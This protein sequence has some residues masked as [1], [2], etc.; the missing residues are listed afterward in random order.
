MS[1]ITSL[2]Q[3]WQNGDKEALDKLIP[4]V[5]DGLKKITRNHLR[6][7][8]EN[9]SLQA[10]ELVNE[11]YIKL[12]NLDHLKFTDRSHFFAVCAIS[13]RQ[14]LVDYARSQKRTKRGG[15]AEILP[16]EEIQIMSPEKSNKLLA[17]DEALNRLANQD[18]LKSQIVE[19]RYFGGLIVEEVADVL[20]LSKRTV[21]REWK[22]AKAWLIKEV[23]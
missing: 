3:D 4:L 15:L 21:E 22:L 20:G 10:T 2:L 12:T 7:E 9:H 8:K 11:L 23:G 18:K 14:L 17:L 1:E 13:V 6:H 19:M 5:F 16:I